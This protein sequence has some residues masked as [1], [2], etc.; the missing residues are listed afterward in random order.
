MA[1]PPESQWDSCV[2]LIVKESNKLQPGSL[3]VVTKQ[4]LQLGRYIE[5][6]KLNIKKLYYPSC[7]FALMLY[8]IFTQATCIITTVI[9]INY[10]ILS[11][12]YFINMIHH[13]IESLAIW[14]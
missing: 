8:G 5:L 3:F 6:L 7:L 4:G 14:N 10:T 13:F 12:L 1:A 11:Q 9:H 2:R